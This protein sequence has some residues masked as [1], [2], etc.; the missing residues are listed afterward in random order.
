MIIEEEY[1]LLNMTSKYTANFRKEVCEKI[2]KCAKKYLQYEYIETSPQ[3]DNVNFNIITLRIK[4]GD[5][6]VS[7]I[8]V[9]FDKLSVSVFTFSHYELRDE[10]KN[11]FQKN[12]PIICASHRY[13][14]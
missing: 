4:R 9:D 3:I 13:G 14:I 7:I 5:A 6:E 2:I 8:K 11:F 1:M 12:Y 10:L